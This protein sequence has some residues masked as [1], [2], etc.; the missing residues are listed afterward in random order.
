MACASFG[1]AA[2][3]FDETLEKVNAELK[4][5]GIS[6]SSLKNPLTMSKVEDLCDLSERSVKNWWRVGL[7]AEFE[8]MPHTTC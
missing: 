8:L 5:Q 6:V 4:S 2:R 3:L 1:V 7:E